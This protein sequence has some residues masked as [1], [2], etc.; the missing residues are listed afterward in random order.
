[1][2]FQNIKK[3]IVGAFLLG[4]CCCFHQTLSADP[5]V[6]KV[7]DAAS[8]S[9]TQTTDCQNKWL[10]GVFGTERNRY[11]D[12]IAFTVKILSSDA[13]TLSYP[14]DVELTM[15]GIRI[16]NT[17]TSGDETETVCYDSDNPQ[18]ADKYTW[19][20]H[21]ANLINVPMLFRVN[22]EFDVKEVTG[23]LEKECTALDDFSSQ[24]FFGATPWSFEL[25]L[26]QLFHLSGE[27]MQPSVAYPVS[28][29]QLI[30]WEDEKIKI[31]EYDLRQDGGYVISSV[32]PETI[33]GTW[34][35]VAIIKGDKTAIDL[36]K[37][38]IS[39]DGNVKW[40]A[41]NPLIQQRE[42]N[43]CI[44][45]RYS[46]IVRQKFSAKQVWRSTPL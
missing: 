3:M 13:E 15:K 45:A 34:Q 36:S 1:M 46:F 24:H 8:Y 31:E 38:A 33:E 12:T 26:T 20:K 14:F 21:L 39:V 44:N 2:N 27:E 5:L 32:D 37:A 7:G 18:D 10:S 43:A 6:F 17:E 22:G 41:A 11:E 42:M 16:N 25:L 19:A 4:S 40:N 30:N 9:V 23:L 28:C 29:Y 35:E